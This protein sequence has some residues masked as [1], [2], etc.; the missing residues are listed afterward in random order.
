MATAA[1]PRGRR[2]VPVARRARALAAAAGRRLLNP[3]KPVLA[4]LAS[5][6]FTVA[7]FTCLDVAAFMQDM[8]LGLAVACPLLMWLEHMIADDE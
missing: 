6:P 5:I 7:G 8:R 3:A 4:N 1:V 2:T